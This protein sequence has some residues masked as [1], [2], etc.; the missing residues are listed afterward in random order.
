MRSRY[1][2]FAVGDAA[3]LL[4]TWHPSTR[5]AGLELDPAVQWRR[6]DIVTVERGGPFDESGIVEFRA[7]FRSEGTV[8]H[9]HERSSFVR[10]GGHWTYLGPLPP[11]QELGRR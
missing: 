4:R 6:L 2:A 10:D 11:A 5:P 9:Q 8:Q 1:A 3:Y 7:Y